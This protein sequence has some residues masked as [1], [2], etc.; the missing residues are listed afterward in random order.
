MHVH[1]LTRR[2]REEKEDEDGVGGELPSDGGERKGCPAVI[3]RVA[4]DQDVTAAPNLAGEEM[5]VSEGGGRG[6][7][8]RSSV[9]CF[10]K[11]RGTP[12]R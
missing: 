10:I 7:R 3:V 4:P 2:T 6:G 8:W 11:R 9:S 5:G 1:Y 12:A